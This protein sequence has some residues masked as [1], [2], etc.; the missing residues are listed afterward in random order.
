[1]LG[2]RSGGVV[3][4]DRHDRGALRAQD[5]PAVRRGQREHDAQPLVAFEHPV[6][7]H[8][9]QERQLDRAVLE[10]EILRRRVV[11]SRRHVRGVGR[12]VLD[13][14][15]EPDPP[16]AAAAAHH[17]QPDRPGALEHLVVGRLEA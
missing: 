13:R 10:D 4:D 7:V 11:G 15:R 9:Q 6:V 12:D 5:R 14:V 1:M 16:H 8:R 17:R 3:V 2:P